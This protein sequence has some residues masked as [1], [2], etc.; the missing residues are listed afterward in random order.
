[1]SAAAPTLIGGCV[2]KCAY[3]TE[4]KANAA[5]RRSWERRGVAVRVYRC[6]FCGRFHLTR[7]AAEA[8]A[9]QA[10]APRPTRNV[11]TRVCDGCG[12]DGAS[13]DLYGLTYHRRCRAQAMQV[14]PLRQLRALLIE[15]A[16]AGQRRTDV[17]L[18]E[19][20]AK[21]LARTGP[22]AASPHGRPHTPEPRIGA[23]AA[24]TADVAAAAPS[25]PGDDR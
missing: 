10:P 18:V 16:D 24:S 2:R 9:A 15:W 25:E 23:E 14:L 13:F 6:T 17:K 8:P 19:Q 5:A 3:R 20:I 1:M 7:Q 12:K 4:A 22:D 11:P 21:N